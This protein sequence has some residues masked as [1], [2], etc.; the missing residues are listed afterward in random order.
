MRVQS[1]PSQPQRKAAVLIVAL[2]PAARTALF[3]SDVVCSTANSLV[4]R[5]KK[6]PLDSARP[7]CS[8][9]SKFFR[10]AF[11]LTTCVDVLNRFPLLDSTAQTVHTMKYIFPRQFGLGSVFVLA[12]DDKDNAGQFKTHQHREEEIFRLDEQRKQRR[13]PS[14]GDRSD[15]GNGE[16]TG[17]KLPKRLRGQAVDLAHRLRMCHARCS[18]GEL[19]K[20]YCPNEVSCF[21]Q[22]FLIHD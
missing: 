12:A 7:V 2:R 6:R 21:I 14:N 18:Y 5:K 9:P 13:A 20:Y 22:R 11:V 4:G 19:L 15:A 3:S 16:N 17:G 1:P 10:A 8:L